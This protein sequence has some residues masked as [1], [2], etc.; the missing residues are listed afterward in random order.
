MLAF[1][2]PMN[3]RPVR[4][5]TA[6]M[7]LCCAGWRKAQLPTLPRSG[8]RVAAR[9][10]PNSRRAQGL[11]HRRTRQPKTPGNLARRERRQKFKANDHAYIAH[12]DLLGGHRW[13]RSDLKS[14]QRRDAH[15]GGIIPLQVAQS[16]RY[17]WR[18]HLVKGGGFRRNQPR[19]FRGRFQPLV[20]FDLVDFEALRHM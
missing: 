3:R 9:S 13:A 14:G 7:T 20:S 2:F 19:T 16:S 15:P 8:P 11:P 4:F 12:G 6:P 17:E 10:S 5:G 1:H 18:H